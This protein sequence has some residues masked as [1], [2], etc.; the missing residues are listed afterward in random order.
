MYT[1][2]RR[3]GLR[4]PDA[5]F[6]ID[7]PAEVALERMRARD[8]YRDV[9]FERDDLKYVCSLRERYRSLA[10]RHGGHV[11]DGTKPTAEL[12]KDVRRL[13]DL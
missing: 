6:V 5:L 12:V 13:A 11:L 10:Q 1:A 4:L 9:V 7:V 3:D 2:A 8:K